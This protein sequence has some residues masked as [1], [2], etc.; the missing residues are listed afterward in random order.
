MNQT[1]AMNIPYPTQELIHHTEPF[2]QNIVVRKLQI[3]AALG[4]IG[5][6]TNFNIERGVELLYLFNPTVQIVI[7][8][9]HIDEIV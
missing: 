2:F 5:V 4:Y 6:H 9:F 7:T 8:Q 1:L 3:S